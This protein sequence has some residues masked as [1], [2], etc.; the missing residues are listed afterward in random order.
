MHILNRL[1]EA[2]L[3]AVCH[4]RARARERWAA[5]CHLVNEESLRLRMRLTPREFAAAED[6]RFLQ[7][8]PVPYDL[9]DVGDTNGH[10][11]P[12]YFAASTQLTARQ[13]SVLDQWTLRLRLAAGHRA[14]GLGA[15]IT[16]Q[17]SQGQESRTSS[18][19]VVVGMP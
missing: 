3:C 11:T 16:K 15:R 2:R 6:L 12:R 18:G 13:R 1:Y 7:P 10:I 9:W 14:S 4:Q 19:S 5:R 8:V 17:S